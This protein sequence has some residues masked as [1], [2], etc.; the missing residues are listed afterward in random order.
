MHALIY[1][2]FGYLLATR[3]GL[4]GPAE[5]RARAR[6]AWMLPGAAFLDLL[7]NLLQLHI[8]AGP[9]GAQTVAIPLSAL[10]AAGK[11]GLVLWFALVIGRRLVSK[12]GT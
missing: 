4:F 3:G 2:V 5:P 1:A 7:E 8:L 9:F 10:C 6:T 12:L 11:W